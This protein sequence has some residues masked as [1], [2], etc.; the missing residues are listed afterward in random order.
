MRKIEIINMRFAITAVLLILSVQSYAQLGGLPGAF[1]RMGFGARGISMGNA[2]TGVITGDIVGYYN[3]AV[4]SFQ[5]E[6]LIGLGYSFLSFDRTLNFVSYTKNFKLPNQKEGG[7]GITFSW[8]NAGVSN[9][10]SRDGDGYQLGS[11]SVSENQFLFAPSF[12]VSDRVAIGVGFKFYFSKLYDGIKST[13]IGFDGGAIIKASDKITIGL[14]VRDISSQYK[15]NT[16]S[17]YQ[18]NGTTTTDKFPVLLTAGASYQLPKRLGMVSVDFQHAS[19]TTSF[20]DTIEYKSNSNIVRLGAEIIPIK[21]IKLRAGFDKLDLSAVD[22]LGGANVMFGLG[23][24]KDLKSYIVGLDYSFVMES[25]SNKPFMTL[26]AV[27][28]IK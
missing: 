5:N 22:K 7:A 11:I 15:W 3:P 20:G 12:R 2:M 10:D 4:S 18:S 1:S 16:S 6:H 19:K 27:F 13:S 9:I 17:I 24:Q 21:D 23:Y 8:I 14:T 28:K 26:S 25:Y